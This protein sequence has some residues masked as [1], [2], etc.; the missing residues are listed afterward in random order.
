ML[1]G[2]VSQIQNNIQVSWVG[3][4]NMTEV[5][6]ARYHCPRIKSALFKDAEEDN[7]LFWY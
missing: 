5:I 6:H 4:K 2:Y 3:R 7:E 1:N